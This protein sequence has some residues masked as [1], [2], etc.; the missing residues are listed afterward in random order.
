MSIKKGNYKCR[1]SKKIHHCLSYSTTIAALLRTSK[2]I[3]V[4]RIRGI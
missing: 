1:I 4:P 3:R 2:N